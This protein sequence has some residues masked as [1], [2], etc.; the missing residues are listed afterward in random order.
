[1]QDFYTFMTTA[2]LNFT[3]CWQQLVH[4]SS[5]ALLT[6]LLCIYQSTVICGLNFQSDKVDL[7]FWKYS[8]GCSR[9]WWGVRHEMQS[10]CNLYNWACSGAQ[11]A[12]DLVH[13][14]ETTLSIWVKTWI[15]VFQ[16]PLPHKGYQ[17]VI[18]LL[19]LLRFFA[20]FSRPFQIKLTHFLLMSKKKN[21]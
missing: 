18:V 15:S 17:C 16:K 1:M 10:G 2:C 21:G 4:L 3:S 11:I 19:P 8:L 5:W 14:G 20:M 9:V 13:I 6:A 7:D 12:G